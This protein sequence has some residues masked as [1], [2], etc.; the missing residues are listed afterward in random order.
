MEVS[1]FYKC[2][3]ERVIKTVVSVKAYSSFLF[4]LYIISKSGNIFA[5]FEMK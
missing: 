2:R 1:S 4:L 5:D 3:L